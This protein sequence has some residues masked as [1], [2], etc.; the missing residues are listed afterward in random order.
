MLLGETGAPYA[1]ACA[2]MLGQ[3]HNVDD[4]CARAGAAA[5]D[6]FKQTLPEGS[7]AS[8]KALSSDNEAEWIVNLTT[9]GV[10]GGRCC[11]SRA[12]R[13]LL[14]TVN[15]SVLRWR[16]RPPAKQCYREF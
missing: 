7:S 9:P 11:C 5:V 8:G 1:C 15:T 3:T 6:Y 10:P 4:R 14:I 2:K 16:Q 12:L 13:Q